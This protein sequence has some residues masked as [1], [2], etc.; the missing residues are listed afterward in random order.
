MPKVP[1]APFWENLG[2]TIKKE[3]EW[4]IPALFKDFASECEAVRKGVGLL[5]LSFRGKIEVTGKDRTAFLHNVLTNDIKSLGLGSGC[6]AALLNPQ[7]RI[8]ADLNLCVFANSLLLDVEGGLEKKL[9]A[10]LEKLVVTEEVQLK[11]VTEAWILLSLQGPKSEALV[12]A[13]IHGPV[14]VTEEFHHTNF[15]ILDTPATLIRRSVT[16]EKGFHLLISNEEG[17]GEPI[18]KR[19]MEVGR[20]YGLRPVGLGAYE[21]LRIEAGIPRYGIDMTEETTLPETGLE[22]IAASET[23]GCYPG[24][25]VVA[26][27]KTYGGLNRRLHG[28]VFDKRSLPK[29]GDR[30]LKNGEE[31]GF[32]TSACDSPALGRGIAL[33][34]LKKGEHAAGDEV[35]IGTPPQAIAAKLSPLPFIRS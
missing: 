30:V 4:E 24:Q 11:D 7:G 20:L 25:E 17:K 3:K 26:R 16:G 8:L 27:I 23:K 32:I 2:A 15:Q 22:T 28:F 21:I 12:G 29:T 10:A 35:T 5:D 18:A 34:Y 19:I 33:G 31:A 9:I 6:Y 13:L 14:M 1:L